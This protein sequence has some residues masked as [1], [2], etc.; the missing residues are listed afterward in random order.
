MCDRL[1]AERYL[2]GL[3]RVVEMI[4]SVTVQALNLR[5]A[6]TDPAFMLLDVR[7][8]DEVN[9]G[10]LPGAYWMPM[11]CVP[12]RLS[13]LPHGMDIIIYCHHGI[14]SLAVAHYLVT[15][16]FDYKHIYNLVGGIDKWALEVDNL[17][18]R[19]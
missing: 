18:P 8:A 15:N 6:Q 13:E 9:L 4:K 5:L 3:D 17:L 14:R 16:G 7:E 11:Q 10:V 2:R 19:Y 1:S 12:E